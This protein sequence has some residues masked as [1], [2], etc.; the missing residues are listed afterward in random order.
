MATLDVTGLPDE[1]VRYLKQLIE[2]WK[3]QEAASAA[4]PAIP[5]RTVD[6]SEFLTKPSYI[7]GGVVRREMAYDDDC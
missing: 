3:R 2:Q 6:P 4:V 7:L 5:K 1:K